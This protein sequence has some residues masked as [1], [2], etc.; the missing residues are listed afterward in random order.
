MG[1]S[2]TCPTGRRPGSPGRLR[3]HAPRPRTAPAGASASGSLVGAIARSRVT[4]AVVLTAS[5]GSLV[6]VVEALVRSGQDAVG[7]V[8]VITASWWWS[9]PGRW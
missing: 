1:S 8:A 4:D 3:A 7:V 9:C 5:V 2:P 6:A